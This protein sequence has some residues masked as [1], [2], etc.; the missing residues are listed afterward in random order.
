MSAG[1]G[2]ATDFG[3]LVVETD[4]DFA[5]IRTLRLWLPTYLAQAERERDLAPRVLARPEPVSYSNLLDDDEFPDSRMPAILVTTAQVNDEPQ[6]DGAGVYSVGWRAVVTAVVR[7]R[8]PGESRA[9]AS[10]FGGSV[11]RCLVQQQDLGGFASETR[12]ASGTM[13]RPVADSTGQDRYLTASLNPLT[14]YVDAIVQAGVG[15]VWPDPED[16][17]PY[18]PPDPSGNPDAPYDPLLPVTTVTT[19]VTAKP[20]EEE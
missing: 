6:I 20:L 2:P 10:I 7:G 8:T 12:L 1:Y 17:D 16:H 3:P 11:R 5:I 15:P 13:L 4:V 18:D 14:V 19:T 9:L